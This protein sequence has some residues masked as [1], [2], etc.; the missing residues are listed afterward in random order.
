MVLGVRPFL[1]GADGNAKKK[2]F[3]LAF[4]ALKFLHL[5]EKSAKKIGP[6]TQIFFPPT[7]KII[8]IFPPPEN[9]TAFF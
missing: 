3:V 2:P 1:I 7:R 6:R 8:I 5:I 4:P 9:K